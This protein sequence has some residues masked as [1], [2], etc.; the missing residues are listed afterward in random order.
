MKISLKILLKSLDKGLRRLYYV[1]VWHRHRSGR[2]YLLLNFTQTLLLYTLL[3]QK[4][5]LVWNICM[6]R[7]AIWQ[8]Q[9][10]CRRS[11][12]SELSFNSCG[13]YSLIQCQ[14]RGQCYFVSCHWTGLRNG[15]KYISHITSTCCSIVMRRSKVSS[16]NASFAIMT[17]ICV[18]LQTSLFRMQRSPTP[19]TKLLS[20]TTRMVLTPEIVS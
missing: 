19:R 17:R 11:A 15:S 14:C 13:R 7:S 18:T 16:A 8:S 1:Y 3:L 4:F 10:H 6:K 20:L 5:S 9:Q 12:A 2:N